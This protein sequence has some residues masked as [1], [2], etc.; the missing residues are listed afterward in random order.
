MIQ[1]AAKKIKKVPAVPISPLQSDGFKNTPA[2][3]MISASIP[4]IRQNVSVIF[5]RASD[6]NTIRNIPIP[7]NINMAFTIN[8]ITNHSSFFNTGFAAYTWS[9]G[10][11]PYPF[12][13]M[14][15]LQNTW[16]S[17]LRSTQR[18]RL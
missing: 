9:F 16:T 13:K 12:F 11:S 10:R 5:R 18:R 14:E 15:P 3:T 1:A 8:S 7:A 2:Q 4:H 17:R 6:S